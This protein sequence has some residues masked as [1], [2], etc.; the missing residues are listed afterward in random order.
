MAHLDTVQASDLK[1][2]LDQSKM[3]P[4]IEEKP[5][6]LEGEEVDPIADIESLSD[7]DK[8]PESEMSEGSEESESSEPAEK[9]PGEEEMSDEELDELLKKSLK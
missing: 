6:G 8:K 9:L 5:P 2:L 1:S 4:V 7:M 3:A